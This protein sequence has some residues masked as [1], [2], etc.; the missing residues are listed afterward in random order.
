M[1]TKCVFQNLWSWFVLITSPGNVYKTLL[2]Q[3][4]F[5]EMKI[6]FIHW[7]EVS[8]GYFLHKDIHSMSS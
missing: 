2:F 4:H 3:N 5:K 8:L 7:K 6:F 1:S